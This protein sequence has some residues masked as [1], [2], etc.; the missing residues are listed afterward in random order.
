MAARTVHVNVGDPNSQPQ[1]RT[2]H[3]L[4][5]KWSDVKNIVLFLTFIAILFHLSTVILCR[6]VYRSPSRVT[7]TLSPPQLL[8]VSSAEPPMTA[9]EQEFD[10]TDTVSHFFLVLMLST[11]SNFFIYIIYIYESFFMSVRKSSCT[12]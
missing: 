2:L 1:N 3:H 10:T 9:A 7:T 5:A 12:I 8:N 6:L 11:V 4:L